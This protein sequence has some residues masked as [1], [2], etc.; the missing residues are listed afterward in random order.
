MRTHS[1]EFS[2]LHRQ[3]MTTFLWFIYCSSRRETISM[4]SVQKSFFWL[5][6]S[7]ETFKN[8]QVKYLSKQL[9]GRKLLRCIISAAKN[10]ISANCVCCDLVNRA[11]WID[12]WEFTA[13]TVEFSLDTS[14]SAHQ[15][16]TWTI[17]NTTRSL[18]QHSYCMQHPHRL[19]CPP[20]NIRSATVSTRTWQR[21][22]VPIQVLILRFTK[23]TKI[24]LQPLY[25]GLI[26]V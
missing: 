22:P 13:A 2:V 25:W 3:L 1:G 21:S 24:N 8:S 9:L 7:H 16:L 17:T 15:H 23:Q 6:N 19:W 10:P 4:S 5:I 14:I 12:T 20:I 26:I 11:I 18:R